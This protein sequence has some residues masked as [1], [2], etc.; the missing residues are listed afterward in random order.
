MCVI[1]NAVFL[2]I[3]LFV[4]WRAKDVCRSCRIH[5]F[6]LWPVGHK[7]LW[8]WLCVAHGGILPFLIFRDHV[9]LLLR[10]S[11]SL[12]KKNLH[13][14]NNVVQFLEFTRNLTQYVELVLSL[15][16]AISSSKNSRIIFKHRRPSIRGNGT[17]YYKT[18]YCNVTLRRVPA[19]NFAGENQY[20][21]F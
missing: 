16:D 20:Y 2:L 15:H 4:L 6:N 3:V 19:R 14:N 9:F 13:V 21:I 7:P 1:F 17:N 12:S 8:Y 11:I 10:Q 5:N 18:M